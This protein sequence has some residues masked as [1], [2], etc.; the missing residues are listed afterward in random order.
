MI[1]R[2][3]GKISVIEK[4]RNNIFSWI[5]DKDEKAVLAVYKAFQELVDSFTDIVA[6]LLRDMGEIIED[7]YSNIEKLSELEA[8][9][10]KQE[11][12][13]KEANGLRNR[14]VHEYNGLE[15]KTALNSIEQINDEIDD[16]V[17]EIRKWIKK[18]S[19]R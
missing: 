12:L 2:Y 14:V 15:Q 9:D 11:S 6:M 18:V 1:K 17:Q 7:D 13:L 5:S 10:E 3:K 19:E 16:I 8:I 4:R